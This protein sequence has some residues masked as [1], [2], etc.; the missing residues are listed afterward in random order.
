FQL[1][2]EHIMVLPS[3]LWPKLPTAR[4]SSLTLPYLPFSMNKT[5]PPPQ[6]ICEG[7]ELNQHGQA[8]LQVQASSSWPVIFH[9][10]FLV[11]AA[12][13][14]VTDASAMAQNAATTTRRWRIGSPL[15]EVGQVGAISR[16]ALTRDND[17]LLCLGV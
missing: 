4:P 17:M 15:V 14:A 8:A 2:N 13:P 16:S 6:F 1:P 10:V 9:G 7:S 11:S 5:W 3:G 12:V